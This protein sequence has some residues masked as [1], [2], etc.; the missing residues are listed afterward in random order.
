LLSRSRREAIGLKAPALFHRK[1]NGGER[2]SDGDD[3]NG[4]LLSL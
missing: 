2:G 3:G 4:R 1:M